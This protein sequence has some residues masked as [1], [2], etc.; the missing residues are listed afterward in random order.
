MEIKKTLYV[1]RRKDWRKWLAKNHKK[2]KEV[3]LIYYR[4]GTGKLRI[5]YDDAVLEA[6]S[7]GWIDSIVKKIDEESFAQRFSPRRPTSILSQMNKE[8]IRELM[9]EKK[10]TKAG[11]KALAHIFN[12]KTDKT[13]KL[14]IPPDILKA[15]KT[16]KQAWKYFKKM[17]LPYKRIRISYIKDRK[18]LGL[19]VYKKSLVHFIKMTAQN[20]RI[21]FVKERRDITI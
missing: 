7:Y 12:P 17:P 5:P 19:D 9:K 16:N 8:R 10:M 14:T 21:G 15:L 18:I 13:E 1:T 6:L 3:W 2:E 11:V 20:K 4:K